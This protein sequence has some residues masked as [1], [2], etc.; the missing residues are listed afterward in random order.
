MKQE[1]LKKI[2][3]LRHELHRHPELS[4]QETE[5]MERLR[6]FLTAYAPSFEIYMLNGWFYAVKKGM[7]PD[8]GSIAFRADMDALPMN[9]GR[10]CTADEAMICA[11]SEQEVPVGK[12][13]VQN[14]ENDYPEGPVES[15]DSLSTWTSENPGVSHKCGHDGHCAALCG[16]AMELDQMRDCS[17]TVYLIFQPAEETGAGGERCAELIREKGISEV[18]AFHN[19]SGYPEGEIVYRRGLTQPASEGLEIR[20]TGRQSHASAPE[21][22]RN[23][24]EAVAAVVLYAG[25]LLGENPTRLKNENPT[26]LQNTDQTGSELQL[27][28]E[29]G[30]N[31]QAVFMKLCTI[32]GVQVG[33]GDFGISPG[34]GVVRMTLRAEIEEEMLEMEEKLLQFAGEQADR[35]GLQISHQIFDYFPETR[36]SDAGLD[37]VLAAAEELQLQTSEMPELWRASED[38]GWYL[39][40][41]PGAVFYVGSGA[42]WPAL[43]TKEYDF[44]DRIL[45]TAVDLFLELAK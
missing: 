39:K 1:N 34:E 10:V 12:M 44:N 19:L 22:G 24:A 20:F 45:E 41:C 3:Q 36:N 27:T 18:Y 7:Q 25:G 9:E 30:N 21:D 14:G 42:D 23:P 8:A 6:V 38:F 26:E 15:D 13:S 4:L 31:T 28:S 5:T 37:R 40:K 29:N 35:C 43:H 33:T 16:L 32:T 2:L 17:R 11:A